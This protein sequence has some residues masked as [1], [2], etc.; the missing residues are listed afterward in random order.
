MIILTVFLSQFIPEIRFFEKEG[1]ALLVDPLDFLSRFG[2]ALEVVDDF[3]P[4]IVNDALNALVPDH[5]L[6]VMALDLMWMAS[7]DQFRDVVEYFC[8]FSLLM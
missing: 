2:A 1:L 5:H 7:I 4:E 6:L 3:D 8:T